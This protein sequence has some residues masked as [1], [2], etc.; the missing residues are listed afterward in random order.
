VGDTAKPRGDPRTRAARLTRG[1]CPTHALNI[2]RRPRR[3][4][5]WTLG[6]EGLKPC[7]HAASV[8]VRRRRSSRVV[9]VCTACHA[10]GRGFE[11]LHPRHESPAPAVFLVA[12]AVVS[13][14]LVVGR[15]REDGRLRVAPSFRR[16]R[17]D[18][19]CEPSNLMSARARRV[20]DV[21]AA[22]TEGWPA[23]VAA[24]EGNRPDG[25]APCRAIPLLASGRRSRDGNLEPPD[26][27]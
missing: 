18:R 15:R 25:C 2:V 21:V 6:L 12:S 1:P 5:A 24:R 27:L 9:S 14:A 16:L 22:R 17:L 10:E 7:S 4:T 11:S 26:P 13:T 8:A 19:H 20:G 23:S 3:A